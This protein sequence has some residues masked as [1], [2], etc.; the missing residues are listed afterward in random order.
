MCQVR[1]CP[2][3]RVSV[4]L[5]W[6]LESLSVEEGVAGSCYD[7]VVLGVERWGEV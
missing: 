7:R 3:V 1:A 6:E 4:W 2:C 5:E